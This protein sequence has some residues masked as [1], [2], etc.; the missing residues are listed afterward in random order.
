MMFADTVGYLPD[1]ILT[2][3]DRAS[4]EH[5]LESRVPLLTPELVE[6]AWSLPLAW[7]E[8]KRILKDV[9]YRHV[10]RR[11]MERPK[12]GFGIPISEWLAGPLKPWVEM[13][14]DPKRIAREGIFKPAPLAKLWHDHQHQKGDYGYVLWDFC[15]FQHWLK[16]HPEVE[17]P[18]RKV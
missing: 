11:L 2:K 7:R 10:P 1:D 3:V 6:F 15:C 8:E 5:S 13:Q 4:M 16:R 9:L 14:L 18:R 12:M 17:I